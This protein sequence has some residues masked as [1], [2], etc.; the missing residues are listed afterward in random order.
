ME[1][2]LPTMY[3]DRLVQRNPSWGVRNPDGSLYQS[4]LEATI[5][6]PILPPRIG[7]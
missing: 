7:T 2:Y 1:L 5:R 3:N 4:L 6:T